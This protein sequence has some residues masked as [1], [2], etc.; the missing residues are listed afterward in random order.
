MAKLYE[1]ERGFIKFLDFGGGV[2]LSALFLFLII[3][4]IKAVM[5]V[6]QDF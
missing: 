3:Y 1:F 6:H 2:G 4:R 5:P